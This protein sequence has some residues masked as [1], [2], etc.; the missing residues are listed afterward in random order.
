MNADLSYREVHFDLHCV[1]A[2][3]HLCLEY[4]FEGKFETFYLVMYNFINNES[5]YKTFEKIL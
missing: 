1:L 5:P 3:M 2:D 4:I